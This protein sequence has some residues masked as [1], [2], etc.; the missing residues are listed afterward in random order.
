MPWEATRPGSQTNGW[1]FTM[2]GCANIFDVQSAAPDTTTVGSWNTSSAGTGLLVWRAQQAP[3]WTVDSRYDFGIRIA[4]QSMGTAYLA[5]DYSVDSGVGWTSLI[6]SVGGSNLAA[7]TIVRS[8]ASNFSVRSAWFRMSQTNAH[9]RGR[10]Q[11][12]DI[13]VVGSFSSNSVFIRNIGDSIGMTD[14]DW[15]G[16]TIVRRP[17]G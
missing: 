15:R 3:Q 13:Y 6:T 9:S 12:W 4:C 14:N 11:L 10:A 5:F 2:V 1:A 16:M 8:L 17:G 7:T